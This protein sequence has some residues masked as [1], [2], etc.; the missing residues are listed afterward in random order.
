MPDIHTISVFLFLTVFLG[1]GAAL[2]TGRNFAGNWRPVSSIVLAGAGIALGVRFL[3]FALYWETLLTLP[4]YLA[5]AVVVIGLGLLGYR[6]R[7]AQQMASQYYWLYERTGPLTWR[8]RT[9]S[10]ATLEGQHENG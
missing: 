9:S 10:P 4:G 7:R 8:E 5:D 2:L 3:H 6:W 1:G